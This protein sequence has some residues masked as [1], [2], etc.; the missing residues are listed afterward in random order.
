MCKSVWPILNIVGVTKRHAD[1]MRFG[2][3]YPPNPQGLKMFWRKQEEVGA[4]CY[5]RACGILDG[6]VGT[7]W[8]PGDAFH[9]MFMLPQLSLALF[10]RHDPHTHRL[11]VGAAGNQCAVLVGPHH[12][13]P[14]PVAC[15]GLH[16]VANAKKK[17]KR[18]VML[19]EW[20]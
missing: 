11:I 5:L 20:M 14:L 12:T 10:G 18:V 8:C 16:T 3:E 9:H 7:L 4:V 6:G 17:V 19:A 2:S 1:L 15:E 13:D